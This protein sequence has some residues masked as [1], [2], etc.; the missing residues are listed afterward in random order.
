MALNITNYTDPG[1]YIGEVVVPGAVS[2]ATVPLTVCLIGA[3]N[4]NK[5]VN[6]E[7]LT[8]GLISN[9]TLTVGGSP[10]AHD[11]TLVNRSNR[12]TAQTTIT[13]DGT[14]LD[15]SLDFSYLA[16][17]VT[18]ASV[19]THNFTAPNNK[20][21]LSLDGKQPI[22]IAITSGA[23]ATTISGNLVTVQITIGGIG[24]V[25]PAEIVTGINKALTDASSLG[26]GPAY[27]AVASVVAVNRVK[28]TSPTTTPV[29]D[30]GLHLPFPNAQDRTNGIFQ[31][32][33]SGTAA[34][35]ALTSGTPTFNAATVIRITDAAYSNTAVYKAAYAAVNSNIDVLANNNVQSM[36]RV[37]VFAGVT[38]FKEN[39]DYSRSGS[40]LDWS[41]STAAAFVSSASAATR[42]LSTNDTIVLSLDG[43][44]AVT[45]DLNGLGSPPPGYANPGTPASATPA[46]ICNNINAVL[47]NSLAY[48]PA[49]QAVATQSSNIITL[50]SPTKGTASF[51]Q[52]AAPTLLSAVTT[53]FGLA[54]TQLPYTVA[55]AGTKPTAGSIYFATY[56]YTRPTS[57][58][59]VVKRF[60]T[61]DSVYQ[62][63]G[64]PSAT[65]QLAMATSIAFENN[66]PSIVVIQ[67]NDSTFPGSPT[68]SELLASLNIAA[69]SSVP[70]EICVLS[71]ALATQVDL[72]NH[73]INESSP[74][75]KL[76]RRGWF[77]MAR[78][79]VIGD[80]DTPDSFVYRS[81]RTLQVPGDSPG[82]GRFILVAPPNV[83]RTITKED[84]SQVDVSLDSSYLA[85]ALAAKMTSFTSPADTLLRK[86]V[87]GF[88]IDD[89]QTYLKAERAILAGNGVTVVTLDAGKLVLLDPITTE[90]GGGRMASFQEISA[91]TQKDAVTVAVAQSVDANLVGIVPSDL[92]S[93]IITIKGHIGGV[94]RSLIAS[95]AIAPF[96]TTEGVT[97]DIDFSKDIQVFQD[98]TDPTRYFFRYFFNLR[99]PAKR[100][101]GEYSVDNPFF[102][103]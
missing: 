63:I 9:E 53:V 64:F 44:A 95:G 1:V 35:P 27:G 48:G 58:Y 30:V 16:A 5:R 74:T 3:A 50:T 99:Y 88:K 20:I 59:N 84:G 39:T 40:N 4:R 60:F 70:T 18:G 80:K 51:V 57:D 82:R 101:F 28:I 37:G 91:S 41:I 81:V 83:T 71:T 103:S 21:G 61:P 78:N 54:S 65:N 73:V 38:S 68:Q 90:A 6:N 42:D 34:I 79:T 52:I 17:E 12:K 14:A 22:V 75:E 89:F 86:T 11:A 72:M 66:A 26:Y 24:A 97:R 77:G 23:G 7:A 13:R 15:S 36:V 102:S 96:K 100:F 55:G 76:Y 92:A 56:E 25:T 93:F 98:K 45:I 33:T 85:V 49:Y 32:G 8:R 47:A 67:T 10:G 43:K 62:D 87:S 29:S 2:A 69:T 46:E 31:T 19:A 94:L